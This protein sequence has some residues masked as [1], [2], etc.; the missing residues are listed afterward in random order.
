MAMTMKEMTMTMSIELW[1]Q[2]W[3]VLLGVRISH[4]ITIINLLMISGKNKKCS[5]DPTVFLITNN[6]GLR[7]CSF[8]NANRFFSLWLKGT[9]LQSKLIEMLP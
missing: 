8:E 1:F 6:S 5:F 9:L 3:F 7:F 2:G 4:A